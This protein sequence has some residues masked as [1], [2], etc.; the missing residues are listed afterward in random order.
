[1]NIIRIVSKK[2]PKDNLVDIYPALT[3]LQNELTEAV[4]IHNKGYISSQ[5]YFPLTDDFTEAN[6]IYNISDWKSHDYWLEWLHS[7]IRSNIYKHYS[8]LD[9][10]THIKLKTRTNFND[11]PLL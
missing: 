5:S 8:L 1:M 7:D 3:L 6:V 4:R 10:E 9:Y 11:I 2:I